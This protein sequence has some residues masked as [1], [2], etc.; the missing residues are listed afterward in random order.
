MIAGLV[1]RPATMDQLEQRILDISKKLGLTHIGSCLSC[2]PILEEIYANK[3]PEDKVYLSGA[4]AHLAH[5]IAKGYNDNKIEKLILEVGIHCDRKAGCDVSGGSLSHC[6]IA[7][8]L[9]LAN[10][11]IKVYVVITEG[12]AQE[13]EEWEFLRLKTQLKLD[14]IK[15]IANL[16]GYTAVTKIDRDELSNRLKVFCHDIDIRYTNNGEGF[17]SLEGHYKKL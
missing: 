10:P 12:S 11:E 14:N 16:N 15:V 9:S 1:N 13:G 8:G 2:L 4:H 5:L 6:G 17:D 3:A 7:I